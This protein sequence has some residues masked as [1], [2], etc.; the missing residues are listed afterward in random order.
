[1]FARKTRKKR[2]RNRNDIS[3]SETLYQC[4]L[5][6][7]IASDLETEVIQNNQA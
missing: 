5:N 6:T 2:K 1:M 3:L 7:C 4:C